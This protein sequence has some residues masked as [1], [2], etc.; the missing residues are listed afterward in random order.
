MHSQRFAKRPTRE[1]VR[2]HFDPSR[3]RSFL[4]GNT[5]VLCLSWCALL[6]AI[7]GFL[8][9]RTTRGSLLGQGLC[10]A[11]AIIV[12]FGLL[13]ML[14]SARRRF[15]RISA[16]E[17]SPVLAVNEGG[18]AL[19]SVGQIP[20]AEMCVILLIDA[21]EHGGARRAKLSGY[22]SLGVSIVV[23]D[24]TLL[25]E[26]LAPE[27]SAR[28]VRRW[29]QPDGTCVG[30][31]YLPL[32]PLLTEYQ[33]AEAF[34]ALGLAAGKHRVPLQNPRTGAQFRAALATAAARHR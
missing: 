27:C 4:R 34:R 18:V 13:P 24:H 17:D 6:V 33:C 28:E 20:W 8:L 2:L 26:N 29:P 25:L 22:G 32:D 30:E 15:Q 7:G 21:S 5:V 3:R 9:V 10:L 19:H 23:W 11:L 14:H 16:E 31:I 1:K 12:L